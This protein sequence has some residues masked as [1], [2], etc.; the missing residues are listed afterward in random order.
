MP[1]VDYVRLEV[2]DTGQGMDKQ[3]LAKAFEPYFTTKE[4]GDGTGLGLAL[5]QAIVEEHDGFLEV[6]SEIGTGTC[7]YLYFPVVKENAQIPCPVVDQNR[8]GHRG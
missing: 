1:R 4:K 6:K 7:F 5:V 8:P 3:T 2:S